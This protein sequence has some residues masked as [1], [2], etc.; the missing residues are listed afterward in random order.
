MFVIYILF[1]FPKAVKC[2]CYAY[3][4]SCNIIFQD[5]CIFCTSFESNVFLNKYPYLRKSPWCY[6]KG[7][8]TRESTK[9]LPNHLTL[10]LYYDAVPLNLI[11][12]YLKYLI[13]IHL[14]TKQYPSLKNFKEISASISIILIISLHTCLPSNAKTYSSDYQLEDTCI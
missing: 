5:E 6:P 1:S 12:R 4:I 2:F 14:V 9:Q 7:M 8:V 11:N 13:L 3:N 10:Q